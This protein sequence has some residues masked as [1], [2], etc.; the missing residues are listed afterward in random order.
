VLEPKLLILDESF[1]GLDLTVR[2]QI[3]A[4]LT[5]AQ[6]RFGTAYILIAH[7]MRLVAR[8]S[9]EIA[10]MESGIIVERG[11]TSSLFAH[12][13]YPLT[14]RMLDAAARLSLGPAPGEA[15]P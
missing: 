13:V 7:D 10:V 5:E 4:L 3:S 9:H 6:Q 12:P 8:F 2:A 14:A 15:R 11:P 1:S